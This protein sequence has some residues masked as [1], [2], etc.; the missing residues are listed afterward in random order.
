MDNTLTPLQALVILLGECEKSLDFR[1]SLRRAMANAH[2]A[3][4]NSPAGPKRDALMGALWLDDLPEG[5]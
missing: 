3:I 2:T 4:V 5:A 1:P